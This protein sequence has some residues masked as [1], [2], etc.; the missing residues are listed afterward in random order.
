MKSDV[1]VSAEDAQSH[2]LRGKGWLGMRIEGTLAFSN[3][4]VGNVHL[5]PRMHVEALD[6]S[7]C[8]EFD[9]LPAGLSCFELNLSN[10]KVRTVPADLCV[11][12]I[13]NLS[14]CEELT[15]LPPDLTVGSLSLRGCRSLKKLPE[16][17]NVWFLDMTGCWSFCEWPRKATIRSGRLTLRGCPALRSLP[18]YLG[19]LAALNVRDCPILRELPESLRITG[20]ID[21]AQSGL[22]ETKRL[23]ASLQGVQLR[24]Q[25]VRIEERIVLRPETIALNEVLGET[26]AERRRVLLDR[27]GVSRFMKETKAAVLDE[28]TDP[29]GKRQLLRVDIKND[30]PLVTLSCFCPSTGRQYFLRVPPNVQSCHQAAAWIAGFD[31]PDDYRPILET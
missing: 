8:R 24:W 29:G 9:E 17:L 30:E 23:P 5:P 10:T 4:S 14:N 7:E 31:N 16:D 21:V 28:D 20:W 6:L 3:V 19:P 18:S 1:V 27:F 25:G 26:N 13:L 11:E 2:L 15:E 12:S 22:A